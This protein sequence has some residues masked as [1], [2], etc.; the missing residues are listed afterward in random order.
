MQG[1]QQV[2]ETSSD[3]RLLC[4]YSWDSV[5]PK[6]VRKTVVQAK[7]KYVVAQKAETGFQR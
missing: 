1:K 2:Y 4:D 3:S 7:P 5:D 6:A